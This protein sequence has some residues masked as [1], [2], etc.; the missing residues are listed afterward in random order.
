MI[1]KDGLE[2]Q[3]KINEELSATDKA[4]LEAGRKAAQLTEES[5]SLTAELKDQLGIRSKNNEGEK[6]LLSLSK[7]ITKSAQEN[8]VALRESGDITKQLK[9]DTKTLE[10]AKREQLILEQTIG[11]AGTDQANAISSRAKAIQTNNAKILQIENEIANTKGGAT[12]EQL[13]QLNIKTKRA[14]EKEYLR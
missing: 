1:G 10:A 8:K 14:A 11:K 5:R 6:T 7:Q 3:K 2:N 4:I 13:K 9:T 12:E